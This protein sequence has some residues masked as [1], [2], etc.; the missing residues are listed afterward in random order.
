MARQWIRTIPK[1]GSSASMPPKIRNGPPGSVKPATS[2]AAPKADLKLLADRK[3]RKSK[4]KRQIS[5]VKRQKE[6]AC[7]FYFCLLIFAFCL[8][9]FFR[10]RCGFVIIAAL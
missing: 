7:L 10:P 1:S 8:L 5:K 4:G 2:P 9:I 6:G 3:E